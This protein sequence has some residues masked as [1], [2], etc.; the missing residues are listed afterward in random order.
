MRMAPKGSYGWMFGLQLV[1]QFGRIYEYILI[2]VG[3]TFLEE[4][5]HWQ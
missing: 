2:E 5:C 4:L 3:V 1:E